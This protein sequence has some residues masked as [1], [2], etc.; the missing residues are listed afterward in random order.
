MVKQKST[1]SPVYFRGLPD[2]GKSKWK[3]F[4]IGPQSNRDMI[5]YMNEKLMA[6][7]YDGT[8]AA[9]LLAKGDEPDA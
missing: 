8:N 7:G 1:S 9:E 5:E 6:L 3:S 4:P 2:S